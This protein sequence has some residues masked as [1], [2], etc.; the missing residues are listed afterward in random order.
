MAE[1]TASQVDMPQMEPCIEDPPS[2][3]A[4]P[5][6]S[7]AVCFHYFIFFKYFSQYI[8]DIIIQ[9]ELN[10]NSGLAASIF[11]THLYCSMFNV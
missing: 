9:K 4:F 1:L 8:H 3:M 11:L 2:L 7:M 5:G 10:V 6:S